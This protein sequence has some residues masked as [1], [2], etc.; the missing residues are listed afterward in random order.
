[1]SIWTQ[2]ASSPNAESWLIPVSMTFLQKFKLHLRKSSPG[3]RSCECLY[4]HRCRGKLDGAMVTH[5]S[6]LELANMAVSRVK[7]RCYRAVGWKGTQEI[8]GIASL[9]KNCKRLFSFSLKEF[10]QISHLPII[11]YYV[12][13]SMLLISAYETSTLEFYKF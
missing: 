3:K 13:F 6:K 5:L 2:E 10:N 1:M 9:I 12:K 7:A 4:C 8:T 11:L